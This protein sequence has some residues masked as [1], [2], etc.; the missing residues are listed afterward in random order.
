MS[1][2]FLDVQQIFDQQ[3]INF[4]FIHLKLVNIYLTLKLTLVVAVVLIK[5]VY[6]FSYVYSQL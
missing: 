5:I 6:F 4:F 1:C 2:K 3:L